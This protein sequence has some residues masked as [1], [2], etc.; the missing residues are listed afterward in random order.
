MSFTTVHFKC[1]EFYVHSIK[2]LNR[3]GFFS[4]NCERYTSDE[5][6]MKLKKEEVDNA[7]SLNFLDEKKNSN[8]EASQQ[9]QQNQQNQQKT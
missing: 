6:R 7:L 5:V 4:S 1:C 8:N 2:S 9:N 3:N